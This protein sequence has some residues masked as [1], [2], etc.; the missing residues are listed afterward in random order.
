MGLESVDGYSAGH[1]LSR[2]S[3]PSTGTLHLIPVPIGEAGAGD[4]GAELS[5][6]LIKLAAGLDVFIAENARSARAFLKRLPLVRPDSG[7]RNPRAE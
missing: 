4:P 6:P 3:R 2:P 1:A 7:D 5:A